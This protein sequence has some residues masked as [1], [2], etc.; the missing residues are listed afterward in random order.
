MAGLSTSSTNPTQRK[1]AMELAG[2]RVG[3]LVATAPPGMGDR[4]SDNG[5]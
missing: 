5:W 1:G 2:R 3:T 4:V